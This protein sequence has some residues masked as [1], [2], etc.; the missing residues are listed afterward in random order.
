MSA[1]D[2]LVFL[3]DVDNT[4]LDNDRV[5]ADLRQHLI[6]EFGEQCAKRYWVLFEA[7]RAEL[8]YA[9][10]LGALQRYR[11]DVMN[12]PRLLQMSSFLL[13]YPFADRL[14]PSVLEVLAY[15]EQHG[16]TVILSDGDVVFQPRKIQRSGLWNA[17]DGR[18][19]VYIH[20]E[21]TMDKIIARYPA[22]H[23][24]MVDDKLRILAAMKSV[25]GDRLTTVFPRQGHYALNPDNTQSYPAADITIEHIGDLVNTD[26]SLLTRSASAGAHS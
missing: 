26:I 6:E 14:Y 18:V 19:L 1:S 23:Y 3:L 22:K 2:E 16:R 20:K 4:L 21:K 11:E 8:G 15:L 17:V 7:L 5:T 13:E 9:D 10:Y 25:L 24:V 12:D